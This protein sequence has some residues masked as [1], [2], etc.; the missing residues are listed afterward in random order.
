MD[1]DRSKRSVV[2]SEVVPLVPELPPDPRPEPSRGSQHGL[3]WFIFFLADVQTGFGPFVAVYLT[4]QKW[5]QV[6][7]GLALSIAGIG[8]LVGQMTGGP[9]LAV[10]AIGVSAL[11]YAA[12]PI[13]PV[14]AA[15]ATLQAVASC[16]LGPAIAAISLG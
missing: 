7:I 3:D 2:G 8:G 9:R 11:A 12:C 6:E 4:T 15:A 10:A 5:K 14:I 13:F 1:D 16:V